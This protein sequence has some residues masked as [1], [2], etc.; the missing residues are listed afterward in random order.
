MGM[1]RCPDHPFGYRLVLHGFLESELE[2]RSPAYQ[3]ILD[4]WASVNLPISSDGVLCSVS[5]LSQVIDQF[6]SDLC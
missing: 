4:F 1:L 2:G 6:A 3:V 5:E